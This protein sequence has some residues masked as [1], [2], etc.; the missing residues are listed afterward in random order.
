MDSGYLAGFHQF[1]DSSRQ[2]MNPNVLFHYCGG[3]FCGAIFA[4]FFVKFPFNIQTD[5]RLFSII[6][7][8]GGHQGDCQALPQQTVAGEPYV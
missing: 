5:I 6:R 1:G 8:G 3:C 7:H 2:V 4:L